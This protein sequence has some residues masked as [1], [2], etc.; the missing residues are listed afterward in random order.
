MLERVILHATE[1]ELKGQDFVLENETNCILGRSSECS[2]H[3]PDPVFMVS[4]L[5]CRIK[6]SAPSVHIQDLG[7]RNGTYLNGVKIGQRGK[8]QSM[9]EALQAEHADHP[10]WDG[11]EL[12]IG[13]HVFRVEFVPP[14][15]CAEAEVRDPE[16]LWSGCCAACR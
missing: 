7:S 12:R 10:L 1:G 11:D 9:K 6:V 5:H 15:P 2:H 16:K 3:L 8:E 13:P 14:P 4:R